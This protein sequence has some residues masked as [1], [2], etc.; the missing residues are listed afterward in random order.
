M[1]KKIIFGFCAFSLVLGFSSPG[2]SETQKKHHKKHR[3]HHKKAQKEAAAPV[4]AP[5]PEAPPPQP[6]P[7][8]T[9]KL[10]VGW[11][12]G[13][14]FVT[15]DQ[16]YSL[17][18]RVRIQPRYEFQSYDQAR[19]GRDDQNTFRMRRAKISWEG[20]AF[21]KNLEYK[22][23]LSVATTDI[24]DLLED[25]YVNY[26]FYDQLQTEFGQFKIPYN[27]QQITSSGRQEFVD[28]SLASDEFR[29]TAIDQSTTRT[30]NLPGGGT[31]TG[32]GITCTGG[33][34]TVNTNNTERK[35]HYDTGLMLQGVAFDRKLEYY[36]SVTNGSGPNRLNPNNE[37]LFLGR[38]V[39]NVLGQYGYSESDVDYSEHPAL[40]IGG[41]GGYNSQDH[42]QAKIE[43]VGGEL[44][45]KYKGASLQGEYYYRHKNSTATPTLG[46]Q[47][48]YVQA[49]YFIIP[50]HFEIAGR[51]SQVFMKGLNNDKG[52]YMATLNYYVFG[53][54]L[55]VQGDY[56]F[57]PT[58]TSLGTANDHRFRLQ[59]QAWF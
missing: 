51:A 15:K 34:S 6:A 52:E 43:Q 30:C 13:L 49:G 22:L 35:F 25:A 48:Y 28:R 10:E 1:F 24:R 40:F 56:A 38:A 8:W 11:K 16:K 20:N 46:G 4:P 37:F 19:E 14:S 3:S 21:T 9:E 39:W 26:R 32:S 17:K 36:A 57:L 33:T 59:L 53:H 55:K 42:T 31:V 18:F 58:Q 12:R 44:G 54:D 41:S 27:R 5:T 2:F 29:W 23:Q 7:T 50:R 47:G 45:F